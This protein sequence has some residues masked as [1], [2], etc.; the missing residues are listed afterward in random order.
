MHVFGEAIIFIKFQLSVQNTAVMVF[1]WA[2]LRPAKPVKPA[3]SKHG[4]Q[5]MAFRRLEDLWLGL[6][7][8]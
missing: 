5:R 3:S 2:F 6:L 1:F 4:K 8:E 7:V